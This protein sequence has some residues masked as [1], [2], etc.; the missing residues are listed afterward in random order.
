LF[1]SLP[2]CVTGFVFSRLN[3]LL[4]VLTAYS[5]RI[6]HL[7]ENYGKDFQLLV[8]NGFAGLQAKTDKNLGQ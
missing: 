3:P 8:A 1:I 7:L 4:P 5:W 2:C 6:I